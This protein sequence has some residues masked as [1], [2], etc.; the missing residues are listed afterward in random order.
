MSIDTRQLGT[1]VAASSR[2]QAIDPNSILQHVRVR[3]PSDTRHR[4][5]EETQRFSE[6]MSCLVDA[7][8]HRHAERQLSAPAAAAAENGWRAAVPKS[9]RHDLERAVEYLCMLVAID[10]RH[11]DEKDAAALADVGAAVQQKNFWAV[12]RDSNAPHCESGDKQ[13]LVRGSAAMVYLLREAVDTHGVHWYDAQALM[14][15]LV[16]PTTGA[17]QPALLKVF[18]GVEDD[19][20]TPM[21]M[22]AVTERVTILYEMAKAK[23]ARGC[24]AAN[25]GGDASRPVYETFLW[26]MRDHRMRLFGQ[27]SDP[28]SRGFLDAL[29]ALHPR[30]LDANVLPQSADKDAVYI[31][32]LKLAQLTAIALEAAF[33]GEI[34]FEDSHSLCVCSDY[35]L[36]KALRVSGLIV[37]DH[38]LAAKVDGQRL[39]AVD[40]IEE[41][42]IR[43]ASTIAAAQ[44]MEWANTEYLPSLEA[45]DDKGDAPTRHVR[46]ARVDISSLDYA[47]WFYGRSFK[48]QPHHL[49]RTVMY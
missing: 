23:T 41:I 29:I 34:R 37:Y 32:F 48:D 30:Y 28:S 40:G 12:V 8:A 35:Q 18:E 20:V 44:L 4:N 7:T 1:L 9:L 27:P 25:D 33:T 22:P 3:H 26:L 10:F 19:G 14:S 45:N 38:E 13:S 2:H 42:E 17:P 36:P 6:L 31:Y 16:E 47:L 11:W 21:M 24:H 46:G 15:S 43:V 49:C 39:L 5:A